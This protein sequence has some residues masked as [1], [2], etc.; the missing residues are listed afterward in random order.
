MTFILSLQFSFA[1]PD[2]PAREGSKLPVVPKLYIFLSQRSRYPF[3]NL[4]H[5]LTRPVDSVTLP[6]RRRGRFSRLLHSY[7]SFDIVDSLTSLLDS[8]LG[9]ANRPLDR[10]PR[11]AWGAT[12]RTPSRTSLC[13]NANPSSFSLSCAISLRS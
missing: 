5:Y 7:G 10:F 9:I 13:L 1:L 2:S 8:L 12:A 4:P 11:A 3:F 6:A